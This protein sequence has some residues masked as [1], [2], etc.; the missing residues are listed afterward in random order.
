[1]D[2]NKLYNNS[3]HTDGYSAL[4]SAF[5]KVSKQDRRQ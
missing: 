2:I 5:P 4:D 3:I 1:M